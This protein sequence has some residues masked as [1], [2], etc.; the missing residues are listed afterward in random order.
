[1]KR[2]MNKAGIG[3]G[4]VGSFFVFD[5]P[6]ILVA[7]RSDLERFA[8]CPAQGYALRH[9]KVPLD[10][11]CTNSGEE[12]HLAFSRATHEWIAS[13]AALSPREAA[14]TLEQE[15]LNARPDVQPD[16]VR[17][18]KWCTWE[19]S[20]FITSIHPENI[21]R[22]DGG[23]DLNRSGQLA[24]DI[25]IGDTIVRATSELDLLYAGPAP[26]LLHEV[27][28]KTG[29]ATWTAAQVWDSFQFQLHAL[30][31]FEAYPKVDGLQVTI[32]N[33]RSNRRTYSVEFERHKHL[34]QITA[35]VRNAAAMFAAHR[36]DE[37]A[38]TWP[39]AE[40]CSTCDAAI[41]CPEAA[42]PLLEIEQAPQAFVDTMFALDARLTE[43]QKAAAAYVRKS[44]KDIVSPSGSA[45]GFGKPKRERKPSAALYSVKSDKEESEEE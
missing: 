7:D 34:D 39:A 17:A 30:L 10:K 5:E 44:G 19:W 41:V 20:R 28:Y 43:M 27:D 32:W 18:V 37:H 15:S 1:M 2:T 13:N 24:S 33:T 8:T 26:A 23:D 22:F 42:A 4:G 31:V 11:T 25:P 29:Y 14:Q 6:T 45:F 38:P 12:A 35:R 9:R 16:V 36:D 40:K 21:L 3:D